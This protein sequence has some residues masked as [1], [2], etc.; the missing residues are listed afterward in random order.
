VPRDEIVITFDYKPPDRVEDAGE[1]LDLSQLTTDGSQVETGVTSGA[2]QSS[3][4]EI[5]VEGRVDSCADNTNAHAAD[6]TA[7]A[8]CKSGLSK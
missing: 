6:A 7:A 2:D 3:W 8:I 5:S 4:D 1:L